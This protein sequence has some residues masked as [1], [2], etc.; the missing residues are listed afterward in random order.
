MA[1]RGRENKEINKSKFTIVLT[2]YNDEE[3][4]EESLVSIFDQ[5]YNNI[6]LIITDDASKN[7]NK[8]MVEEIFKKYSPKN[9][10]E[11][12]FVINKENIGTVKT[13]N[14]ALKLV[15]GE[16]VLFF[17]SDD[18][19]ASTNIIQNYVDIFSDNSIN[20]ITSNWILCDEN[21]KFKKYFQKVSLLGKFNKKNVKKQYIQLCK[22]N[23]YGAGSTCYRKSL[24]DKYGNFDESFK[25]LEDWPLWLKLTLNNERIYYANLDGLLHRDGG[26]SHDK[27]VSKVKVDF[28]KEVLDLYKNNILKNIDSVD[29]FSKVKIINSYLYSIKYYSKYFDTDEY[30]EDV[31]KFINNNKKFKFV[32]LIDR[33]L[34]KYFKKLNI[35]L[36]DNKSVPISFILTIILTFIGANIIKFNNANIFLLFIIILYIIIYYFT[37]SVIN[38]IISKRGK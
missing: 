18:K 15:T 38:V 4:L 33:I 12:K 7:F 9:I 36:K 31:V 14:E 8:N 27:H 17:A 6:E 32:T 13:V 1:S 30:F 2:N 11:L 35:L 34:P 23:I 22:T 25:Y 5:T 3:Y 21:L 19:L 20:A 28:F 24:F 10:T 37:C 29:D 16:Y 26:I